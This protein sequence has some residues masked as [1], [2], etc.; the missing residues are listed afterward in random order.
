M[1][2]IFK[3]YIFGFI[4]FFVILAGLFAVTA[5][6]YIQSMEA[7]DKAVSEKL[8]TIPENE[9]NDAG[10]N[11]TEIQDKKKEV[12]WLER[13]LVLAKYDSLNLGINLTDSIVQVQLKGTVLFQAKIKNQSP[14]HFFDE[15]NYGTYLDFTKI[16][17]IT[18]EEATIQKRPL[19]RVQA[20]KNEEEAAKIKHDSIPDPLLV[21]KFKLDN[22]IKVV[23]TGIGLNKDSLIDLR[24]QEELFRYNAEKLKQNW[25][26]ADDYIPTLYI[27]LNDKDAKA[28]YRA[29]PERG[30]VAFRN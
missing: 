4:S 10:W 15:L 1:K 27:W 6:R 30:K 28:V 20:P 13:N 12:H 21:W 8:S 26:S 22:K 25:L 16:A 23:I 11:I 17:R 14:A 9:L 5:Y 24:Y 18:E 2:E 19:K 3:K 29:I 7:V